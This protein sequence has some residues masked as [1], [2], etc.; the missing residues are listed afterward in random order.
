[1][2]SL[3]TKTGESNLLLINSDGQMDQRTKS[4]GS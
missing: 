2:V 3:A 4:I 1:L